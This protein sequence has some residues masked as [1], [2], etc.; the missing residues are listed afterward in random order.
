MPE[1]LEG[2]KLEN[3]KKNFGV[4]IDLTGLRKLFVQA[5]RDRNEGFE[6]F[7][8][9]EAANLAHAYDLDNPISQ[10]TKDRIDLAINHA[11]SAQDF[12]SQPYQQALKEASK[13]AGSQIS[14]EDLNSAAGYIREK[15]AD[16]FAIDFGREA[17]QQEL[18]HIFNNLSYPSTT[19]LTSLDQPS[20]DKLLERSDID[21][22]FSDV[23]GKL[24]TIDL[25]NEALSGSGLS[26]S[27]SDYDKILAK[28][29]SPERA[30]VM[31]SG[32]VKEKLDA[33]AAQ[34]LEELKPKQLAA[35]EET[36]QQIAAT[37]AQSLEQSFVP[38]IVSA[39]RNRG[40]AIGPELS[41][42]LSEMVGQFGRETE[43]ILTPLRTQ[44]NLG[45]PQEQLNLALSGAAEAGRNLGSATEF[46]KNLNVLGKQQSFT[47]GQSA[48]A[49]AS[50][51]KSA[52]QNNALM[53]ALLS[54]QKSSGPT[55]TDYF[56]QY[57][58]PVL[59]QFLGGPGGG[60]IVNLLSG[61]FKKG[62]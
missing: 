31:A 45:I 36:G 21:S 61:L 24:I 39:I 25:A 17:S 16:R 42:V 50:S 40:L 12:I 55:S 44:V 7:S 38:K 48:L 30:D 29:I 47:A 6:G 52:L 14:D 8:T 19:I 53:L 58:L 23:G 26:L 34:Q 10:G 54:G 3:L 33:F 15:L 1:S 57:G 41:S 56:L 49:T 32:I 37:Q 18:S 22:I 46:V 13:T 2:F 60:N 28:G 35:I 4:N 20:M 43:S 27:Q 62:G 59:G 51:E 5:K 11:I 9:A